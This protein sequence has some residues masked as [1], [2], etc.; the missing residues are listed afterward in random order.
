MDRPIRPGPCFLRE[1]NATDVHVWSPDLHFAPETRVHRVRQTYFIVNMFYLNPC[2]YRGLNIYDEKTKF[3]W[4]RPFIKTY[5][6]LL[7]VW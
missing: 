3:L 6:L 2:L 5:H 1:I 7:N 4:I